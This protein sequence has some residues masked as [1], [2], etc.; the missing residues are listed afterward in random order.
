MRWQPISTAPM[1]G[2]LIILAGRSGYMGV[3]YRASVGRFIKGYRTYWLTYD[4]SG[5][6]DEGDAQ[7]PTHWMPLLPTPFTPED[8]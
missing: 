7:E 5:F 8:D 4:G 2:T 1:D 3:P 6:A